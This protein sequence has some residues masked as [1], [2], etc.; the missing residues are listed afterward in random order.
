MEHLICS[1]RKKI[2]F[3][4][5]IGYLKAKLKWSVWLWPRELIIKL[6]RKLLAANNWQSMDDQRLARS[7]VDGGRNTKRQLRGEIRWW[8]VNEHEPITNTLICRLLFA[9]QTQPQSNS[10]SHDG[11]TVP[12]P[13]TTSFP[14]TSFVYRW[15]VSHF[16]SPN[17]IFPAALTSEKLLEIYCEKLI[18]LIWCLVRK[19]NVLTAPNTLLKQTLFC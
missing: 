15:H 10:N 17:I 19:V 11:M 8:D 5:A 4:L 14:C 7:G 3:T 6:F 2:I 12:F 9:K 16:S 13:H 18:W 1:I